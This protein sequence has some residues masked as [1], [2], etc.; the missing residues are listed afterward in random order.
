[1]ILS[2]HGMLSVLQ[3]GLQLS[4]IGG[5]GP[6]TSPLHLVISMHDALITLPAGLDEAGSFLW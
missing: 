3:K 5:S 1:M 4:W 6:Q 2:N